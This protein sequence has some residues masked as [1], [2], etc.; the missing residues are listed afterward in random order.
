MNQFCKSSLKGIKA[1]PLLT[2]KIIQVKKLQA[3]Q[4]SFGIRSTLFKMTFL[5]VKSI[6]S[7]LFLIK[8]FFKL[9]KILATP[10]VVLYS[11]NYDKGKIN[12]S[13]TCN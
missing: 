7:S 8:I 12:E 6:K 9:T 5:A 13:K 4:N 3:I 2:T 11:T 1:S 10:I